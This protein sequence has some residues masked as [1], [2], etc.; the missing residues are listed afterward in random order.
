MSAHRATSLRML[1]AVLAVAL[2]ASPTD[3]SGQATASVRSDENFRREPN[4]VILGRLAAGTRLSVLERSGNWIQADVEGWV[5]LSSLQASET[6]F[7]L[8]VSVAGGENL[9]SGPSGTVVGRLEEG[10]LLEELGREPGWAHVRRRGWI[11]SA[12]VE[13]ATAAAP[14]PT[15]RT[16]PAAATGVA[17]RGAAG[18]AP[19]A[20]RPEGF[21]TVGP[22][23]APILT[24]PDGDTL[25]HARPTSDLQIVA[26][27]GN[28]ARVRLEGWVWMPASGSADAPAPTEAPAALEPEDLT[29]EPAAHVGRVV[30]WALQFISLER[31]EEIRTDFR[32]GE[33]FLLTRFGGPEG[34]FVYVAVPQERLADMQGLVPLER[35]SVTARVR[36]GASSFTGTP[37]VD[38]LSL[39]RSR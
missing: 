3:V 27:E 21:A 23:G 2:L 1:T 35:I 5:W 34:P 32:Q 25:A 16:L 33:P 6:E 13:E 26:R 18:A 29:R 17:G 8:V 24:S 14:A 7:D 12:S 38:L 4:G 22:G 36:T 11:W 37:I 30:S 39:E 15:D 20:R 10:T 31:A 19:P 28:W 9:R